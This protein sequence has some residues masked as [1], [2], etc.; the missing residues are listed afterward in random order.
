MFPA[1]TLPLAT[2]SCTIELFELLC[3]NTA[4]ISETSSPLTLTALDQ[5][6]GASYSYTLPVLTPADTQCGILTY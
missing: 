6:A 4:G 5:S 3:P 1:I 2:G